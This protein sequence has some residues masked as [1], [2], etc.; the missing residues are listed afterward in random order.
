[1]SWCHLDHFDEV[2]YSLGIYGDVTLVLVQLLMWLAWSLAS[3]FSHHLL[4]CKIHFLHCERAQFRLPSV[5]FGPC[6]ANNEIAC[7]LNFLLLSPSLTPSEP[8]LLH[9]P[10]GYIFLMFHSLSVILL[11][12]QTL[13][14]GEPCV[15][16]V[17]RLRPLWWPCMPPIIH[18]CWR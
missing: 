9:I 5:A 7:I 10:I 15:D 14:F 4:W 18:Y 16:Q 11:Q 13:D 12:C 3:G 1:M 2:S 8:S 17:H 6:S